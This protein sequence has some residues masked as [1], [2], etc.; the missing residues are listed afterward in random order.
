MV[1]AVSLLQ[2]WRADLRV[3]FDYGGDSLL[4]ALVI[5]TVADHGWYWV[6]PA[7]GAPGRL[8]LYDYPFTAHDTFHVLLI[9]MMTWCTRDWAL[10]FNVYFLLGFPLIALS[11]MAVLRRFG[12]GYG[13]SIV[14][15]VLYAFLPS[16]LLKGEGHL[17][18]D[19][20]YQVPLAVLVLL[21][22]CERDPPLF[23]I[24][25][26]SA[27]A[28]KRRTGL[29][30]RRG[31]SVAALLICA[32]VACTSL[33][34]AFFSICLLLAGGVWASLMWRS[35]RNA[36]AGLALAGVIVAGLGANGLPTLIYQAR[37]GS[38]VSVGTRESWEAETYGMK[39]AQLLLPVDGHR[40]PLLERLKD[41]YNA[42]AP[43]GGENGVTSLG[44]VGDVGFLALFGMLLSGRHFEGGSRE[45]LRPL[46]VF[47]LLSVLLGT[48]GGF[49]SLIAL[50]VSPQ[51]RT[52]SRLSV[53]IAF[54][55]LF[56]V[57]ALLDR[58]CRRHPSLGPVTLPLVLFLGL[59]DQGTRYAVR[60]YAATKKQYAS[61]GDLV[62]RI[63]ASVPPGA[64]IFE[65]PYM[66]FPEPAWRERFGSS[67]T[68]DPPWLR[69]TRERWSGAPRT[70]RSTNDDPA[71][72]G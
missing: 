39:I 43:L 42:T 24:A 28:S 6:N 53:F 56:A 71:F 32:F 50:L 30:M 33:Y 52:Y 1:A 38:N 65:L 62:R 4:F 7:V 48:I 36:V 54:F 11:A 58:L 26:S 17:F 49:G 31:R 40:L 12:V 29:D 68:V 2:L 55:A 61:D 27:S 44:L 23:P 13:P 10:V 72:A 59:Y 41:R 69:G 25:R 14:V 15:S 46:A 9:K 47:N 60:H 19:S 70:S 22:V 37:H 3:P 57:A 20:F 67:A 66:T 45:V 51:I 35:T 8:E 5:K 18:L 21:W 34:Y 16:R 63:E 64:A